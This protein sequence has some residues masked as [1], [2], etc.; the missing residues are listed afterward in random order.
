M[1]LSTVLLNGFL[2][3]CLLSLCHRCHMGI[4]VFCL[5]LNCP[6]ESH[7]DVQPRFRAFA[8]ELSERCEDDS[9]C[10]RPVLAS[11]VAHM[12]QEPRQHRGYSTWYSKRM[13]DFDDRIRSTMRITQTECT[14]NKVPH[15]FSV[16]FLL[17]LSVLPSER[18]NCNSFSIKVRKFPKGVDRI[19]RNTEPM[20]PL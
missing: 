3:C 17:L 15:P 13:P 12:H 7:L 16:V 6:V 11:C 14:L 10:T 19:V 9:Q 20:C 1:Y 8:F 18:C 4:L 5:P 2:D